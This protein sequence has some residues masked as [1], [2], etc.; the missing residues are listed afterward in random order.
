V[1]LALAACSL[2]GEQRSR[3]S[4]VD[5]C[6]DRRDVAYMRMREQAEE[7]MVERGLDVG[8]TLAGLEAAAKVRTVRGASLSREDSTYLSRHGFFGN[9]T[10]TV[11]T[12][13]RFAALRTCLA[14][15]YGY[16]FRTIEVRT[17]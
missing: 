1:A 5:A 8:E 3:L 9:Y 13:E 17:P 14:Q 12:P 16:T 7:L 11:F 4:Q 10:V 6:A 15:R 2:A